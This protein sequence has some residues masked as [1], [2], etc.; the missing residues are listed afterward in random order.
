MIQPITAEVMISRV[1][2]STTPLHTAGIW[3]RG[4]WTG[5][6]ELAR[7]K[8]PTMR[9]FTLGSARVAYRAPAA[10]SAVGPDTIVPKVL[11]ARVP[12]TVMV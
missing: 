4:T 11:V 10:A 9:F 7:M 6:E 3:P 8:E 1:F 2:R 5:Q 12:A